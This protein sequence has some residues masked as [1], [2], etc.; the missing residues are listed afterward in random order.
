MGI[1][2]EIGLNAKDLPAHA[3]LKVQPPGGMCQATT[4]IT[5]AREIDAPLKAWLKQAFDAA[6]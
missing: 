2:I 5:S 1:S 4:R 6:G 3:R